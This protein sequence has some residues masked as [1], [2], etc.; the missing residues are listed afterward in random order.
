MQFRPPPSPSSA[1]SASASSSTW[2]PQGAPPQLPIVQL[3]DEEDHGIRLVHL[4][5]TCADSVQR[6][7]PGLALSLLDE[8]RPLL[9]RVGTSFGIGKVAGCFVDALS[10]RIYSS[11]DPRPS[12][13]DFEILYHHFYE[14]C[15]DGRDSL[16]E[17]GL[18]LAELARSVHVRFAFRGVA[19]NRLDDVKPWM[20]VGISFC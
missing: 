1:S 9:T 15:P 5:M 8:M 7:D 6:G 10:R 17:V 16:R 13:S 20:L 4:L 2:A 12:Q 14:A 11:P 18:R 19:A 3:E